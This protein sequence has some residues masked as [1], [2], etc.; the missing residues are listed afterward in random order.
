MIIIDD[1]DGTPMLLNKELRRIVAREVTSLGYRL[2]GMEMVPTRRSY[3]IRVYIDGLQTIGVSDCGLVNR[4]LDMCMKRENV[5]FEVSSPGLAR[6]FFELEQYRDYIGKE[7]KV[8][9]RDDINGR[10]NFSG[11]L[12]AVE[13]DSVTLGTEENSLRLPYSCIEK[14]QLQP[15][16]AKLFK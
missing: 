14:G 3:L 11:R 6:K 13:R 15:D 10:R 7:V 12:L 9:T 8:R 4:H 2:W 1:S 5:L 16:Y